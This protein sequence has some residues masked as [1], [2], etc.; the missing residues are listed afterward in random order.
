MAAL[1]LGAGRYTLTDKLDY[2]AGIIFYPKVGDKINK[3]D[4]LIELFTDKENKL[5]EV[6]TC[7]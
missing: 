5:D 4:K 6:K 7:Q 3:G 2:K 1:E